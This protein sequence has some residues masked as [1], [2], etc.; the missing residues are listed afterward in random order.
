MIGL[1]GPIWPRNGCWLGFEMD[2]PAVELERNA[3]ST[4]IF[5][6]LLP[7]VVGLICREVYVR[8]VL[9]VMVCQSFLVVCCLVRFHFITDAVRKRHV[10]YGTVLIA[11]MTSMASGITDAT[12]GHDLLPIMARRF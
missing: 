3:Q 8:P 7:I 1:A 6:L 9:S 4:T 2:E 12:G 11:G 10:L 5:K